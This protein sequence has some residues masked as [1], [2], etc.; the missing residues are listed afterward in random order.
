MFNNYVEYI[1][2]VWINV[3]VKV[4][5]IFLLLFIDIF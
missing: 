1:N 4:I 5:D 3:E 2:F